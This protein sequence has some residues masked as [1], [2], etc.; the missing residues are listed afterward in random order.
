MKD[1]E[2]I[3]AYKESGYSLFTPFKLAILTDLAISEMTK[4]FSFAL[5]NDDDDWAVHLMTRDNFSG[6]EL[7]FVAKTRYEVV[8]KAFQWYRGR[9]NDKD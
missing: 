8:L 2:I 3:D 7:E 9:D 1:Q 4:E 6:V 5:D